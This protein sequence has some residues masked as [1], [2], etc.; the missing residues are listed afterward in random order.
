M[1]NLA[2]LR[3]SHI[4]LPAELP[5]SSSITAVT[6]D[7]DE[8]ATFATVERQT[9]DADVEVE[10]WRI[11]GAAKWESELVEVC[12]AVCWPLRGWLI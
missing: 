5:S 9:A 4:P 2:L 11:G 3:T 1:R 6:L 7:L 12:R 8:D 10:V